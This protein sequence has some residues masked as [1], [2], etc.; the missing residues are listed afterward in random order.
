MTTLFGLRR[1]AALLGL[2]ATFATRAH[3]STGWRPARPVRLLVGFPPG[4]FTDIL[5]R[6]LAPLLQARFEVP[7]VVENRGGAAGTLAAEAAARANP[8]GTTLLIGHSTANAIAAGL[9]QRLTY[10]PLTAFTPITLI[11]AQPHVLVVNAGSP[12][13]SV[14]DL[15][16]AARRAP[17]RLTFASSGVGSVQHVAGEL[18]RTAASV[19]VIH[20]PYRGSGPALADLAGGQVDF[21]IDGLAAAGPLLAGGRLRAL[22]VSTSARVP[23]LPDVPTFA[24]AGLAGVEI[25]S[26]FALLG[27]A[28]L[29]AAS[30]SALHAATVE[31]LQRPELRRV[32]DEASAEPGGMPPAEFGEFILREIERYRELAARTQI[33]MD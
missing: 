17:G 33:S 25:R 12:H 18:F 23:R 20:V 26:W 11:A 1:R 6:A 9:S 29:P 5:A 28:G 3:A 4:G 15:V 31:A 2:G 30:V 10:D 22:A 14:A 27:P 24:E 16:G 13:A 8:D 21:A 19:D 32:L 7:F